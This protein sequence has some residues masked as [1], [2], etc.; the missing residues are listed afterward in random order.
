MPNFS[1][2]L[3]FDHFLSSQLPYYPFSLNFFSPH[4]QID[5]TSI[6]NTNSQAI[7]NLF[8]DFPDLYYVIGKKLS[9]TAKGAPTND[10]PGSAHNVTVGEHLMCEVQ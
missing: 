4:T 9:T 8:Q 7:A 5:A 2:S 6:I 3:C 1:K 10:E